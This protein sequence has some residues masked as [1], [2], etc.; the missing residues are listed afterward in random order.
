MNSELNRRQFMQATAAGSVVL[1]SSGILGFAA[2]SAGSKIISPGCRGSKVKVARLF[3]AGTGLWP[4]PDLRLDDEVRFYKTKFAEMQ[5][6]LNDVQWVVDRLITSTSQLGPLKNKIAQADGVLVIQLKMGVSSILK[7]IVAIGRP[8]MLFAV[9]YSGHEWTGFGDMRKKAKVDCMLTYDYKQLAVAIRP[10]RA[11]H[12]LR[13]AKIL[14]LTNH[15]PDD[16]VEEVK[17]SFGTEIKKIKLSRMVDFYNSIPEADAKAEADLW[18][19]NAERVVEP[20][21]EE[22]VKSC[23][24]ALA[25][26]KLLDEENATVMTADCYGSMYKPLCR[27]YAFPCIGFTRLNNMGLGGICESD[28]QS[29]MTHIIYQGLSGRPGFISDPTVDESEDTIICAHCLGTTKMDGPDGP[30]APYKIRTIMERR[31]GAVCQ[32]KMRPGQKVTEAKLIGTNLLLYFTGQITKALVSLEDDR[33]CR[34]KIAV[35]VDG[36]IHKLWHNWSNGLHRV[37]CYGDLSR[38]LGYFC[39]FKGIKLVNE[40]V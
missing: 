10:F 18:I 9:P 3:I 26:E 14:D 24:L 17:R 32:V 15:P 30:A 39:K 11:I 8:T 13:E 4:K 33:G 38:E 29:A 36:D 22:I 40:A 20:S 6:D 21:K 19:K 12:H 31:Q 35:K 25:F 2:N 28:L 27:A 16:Y 1:A 5:S 7:A 37:T 23:R 34:T